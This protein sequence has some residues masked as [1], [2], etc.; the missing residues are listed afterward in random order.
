MTT[1]L[2]QYGTSDHYLGEKG[3]EY[4][5]WQSAGAEFAAKITAHNFEHLV[6]SSHTVLDF[7]CGGGFVLNGLT[8]K[9][10]IGV[11][12]NPFAR[13]HAVEL[14]IECFES[15]KDVPD[16]IVD[17]V[18]S[19]HTLEHVPYPI[20]ALR[21]LRTK[22]KPGGQLALCVPIDNWRIQRRY[23]PADINHHLHTWT[24]Q[25]LGN[26][27]Y[28]AGFDVVDIRTRICAWPGRWT[29]ATYGRLPL[30][31]FRQIC[32]WYGL[33]TGKG[34]EILAIA[35]PRQFE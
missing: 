1:T 31:A 16:A 29:V 27:L 23:D 21:E 18:I 28:D 9:R 4:F 17:L 24:P 7:G 13:I 10:R 2:P 25:L 33:C 6:Q 15:T 20:A 12:I 32:Y 19:N 8:C 34:R 5:R 26:T 14:G 3:K 22:L 35:A 11:E 30:W